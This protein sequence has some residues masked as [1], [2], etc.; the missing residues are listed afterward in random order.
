MHDVASKAQGPRW[1]PIVTAVLAVL[2]SVAGWASH[3]RNTHSNLSKS[4]AIIATTLAGHTYNE[5]ESQHTRESVYEALGKVAP[6]DAAGEAAL[7]A[8]ANGYEDASRRATQRSDR[9]LVSYEIL[10]GA[11][12]L[13][14]IA[15]VLVSVRALV[16]SRLLT[17]ATGV[18]SACGIVA[19][20]V[21]FL[22]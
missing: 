20:A 12:T 18:L 15:I 10:E 7:L 21:G 17:A 11:T 5:Y 4:D 13:F 16:E 9:Y 1:I 6:R 19:C 2:A 14:E 8:E 3:D 22:Y